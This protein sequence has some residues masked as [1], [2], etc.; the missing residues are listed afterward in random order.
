[1]F[2]GYSVVAVVP[3]YVLA[4]QSNAKRIEVYENVKSSLADLGGPSRVVHA[5][6]QA[7]GLVS[8][9]G[10]P[11]W[12]P[13][14]GS[15]LFSDMMTQIWTAVAEVVAAGDTPVAGGFFW[16]QGEEDASDPASAAAY[17]ANLEGFIAT[18]RGTFG[19]ES[20][21]VIAELRTTS[22]PWSHHE[23]VRDAQHAVANGNDVLLLD[24]DT[25]ELSSDNVHYSISGR[26]ELG[27][28][29][30]K[31]IEARHLDL[32]GSID[33]DPQALKGTGLADE[34]VGGIGND[35]LH[36][37][38]GQDTLIGGG[39]DDYLFGGTAADRLYGGAGADRLYGEQGHD[40]LAGGAGD[41]RLFGG[42]LED[43]MIGGEGRDR[44]FFL[45]SDGANSHDTILDFQVGQDFLIM[46]GLGV[47][48]V[49]STAEGAV[50]HFDSG[51]T[52]L[53][54]DIG[55]DALT[56]KS[57]VFQDTVA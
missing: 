52:V 48:E 14:S 22:D 1:M 55:A 56:P 32:V 25:F 3:I 12:N 18:L 9:D 57:F 51:A 20:P 21:F 34:L 44:F 53:L 19:A 10:V 54:A 33:A 17:Q 43:T 49:E 15:D 16:V 40:F 2:G 28:A 27:E 39:G 23:T 4:G 31:T 35:K 36:G 38:G 30:V 6:S 46:R 8:V 50:V 45:D 29:L 42:V 37:R 7:A 24:T 5:G 11:D 47:S 26:H 41:D 13:S